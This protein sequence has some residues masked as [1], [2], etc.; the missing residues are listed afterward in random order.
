MFWFGH[1]L[2]KNLVLQQKIRKFQKI[3]VY[4]CKTICQPPSK[5]CCVLDISILMH[6][7]V[8][9][10]KFG[11]VPLLGGREKSLE[12]NEQSKDIVKCEYHNKNPKFEIALY[13]FLFLP[14]IVEKRN[15]KIYI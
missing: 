14:G 2:V 15:R 4:L 3:H 1:H 13:Y 7:G 11:R 8:S 10:P 6:E 12:I 5:Q 9:V